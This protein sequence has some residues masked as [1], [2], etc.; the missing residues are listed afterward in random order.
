MGST[1]LVKQPNLPEATWTVTSFTPDEEFR[2]ET[3]VRGM[4]F[5]AIHRLTATAT[6]TQSLL[7]SE[8]SGLAVTLLGPLMRSRAQKSLEQ[9]N[10]GLKRQ[11]EAIASSG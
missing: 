3:R 9:E 11:S 2:W 4:Y 8:M 1:A 7:R 5:I 10:A 6:G